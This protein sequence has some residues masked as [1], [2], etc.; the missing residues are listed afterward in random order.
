MNMTP[1]YTVLAQETK[2]KI[3]PK[4]HSSCLIPC[5]LINSGAPHTREAL[6]SGAPYSYLRIFGNLSIQ[7]ILVITWLYT[8]LSAPQENQCEMLNFLASLGAYNLCLTSILIIDVHIIV[9]WQLSKQRIYWPASHDCIVGSG[10]NSSKSYV[11]LKF[12][13][14]KLLAFNWSQAQVFVFQSYGSPQK[15]SIDSGFLCNGLSPLSEVNFK[16]INGSIAF[17]SG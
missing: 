15:L 2:K 3:K 8:H 12:S 16:C 14:D 17:S 4:D 10:A 11:F 13:T 1:G 9:N 7:N 5:I 6:V